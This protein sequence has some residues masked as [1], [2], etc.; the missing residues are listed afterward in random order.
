VQ[1]RRADASITG[2]VTGGGRAIA[3]ATVEL[4]D[5]ETTRNTSTAANPIGGF[6]FTNVPPGA[7]TLTVTA[8]GFRRTVVIVAAN[9]GDAIVRDV[10]LPAGP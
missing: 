7:Y 10:D 8:S 1:L 9:A 3:G 5:G 2:T 6:V 4:T